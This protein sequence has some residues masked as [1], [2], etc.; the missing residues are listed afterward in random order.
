MDITKAERVEANQREQR[1]LENKRRERELQKKLQELEEQR[2]EKEVTQAAI[3]QREREKEQEEARRRREESLLLEDELSL[4][5]DELFDYK[6]GSKVGFHSFQGLKIDDVTQLRIGVI[7]TTKSGI[8]CFIN[9][10]ERA[11]R[12]AERGT[13]PYGNNGG[14]QVTT[15]PQDYLPE[16][17]FHLVDIPG[18]CNYNFDVVELENILEGEIQPGFDVVKFFRG[19]NK[20][21][22]LKDLPPCPGFAYRLHGI[23]F[24]FNG[25]CPRFLHGDSSELAR[26]LL[27][28]KRMLYH[29]GN[30]CCCFCCFYFM[31]GKTFP[32]NRQTDRNAR[33]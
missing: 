14:K 12:Q 10:C 30:N 19:A 33:L 9:G 31:K 25:N 11:L 29:Y 24:V 16:M 28:F 21:T 27:P 17:F 32:T 13:A 15:M 23:I 26:S 22:E 8:S 6:F 2:L 20:K 5:R 1:R 18:V 3:L 4:R 7:G